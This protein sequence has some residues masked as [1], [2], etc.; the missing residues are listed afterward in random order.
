MSKPNSLKPARQSHLHW[1][2]ADDL[3]VNPVAQRE[4]NLGWANHI[5][6]NF[7]L[8]KMQVPHVNKR[9]DGSLYIMEGQHTVWAYRQW[10]GAGQ[11][12]QVWLYD[13]LSEREEAEFFLSLNDKKGIDSL[14][15]FR[16][17]VTAG[18]EAECDIDRIVR[19]NGAVVGSGKK[20]GNHISA[21]G[22][23]L[24]I[25]GQHGAAVLGRTIRTIDLAFSEGGYE[26][27]VLLGI[28]AVYG[29]YGGDVDEEMLILK[30]G[31]LRNGWKTLVQRAQLLRD[32][33]GVTQSV[34]AAAAVVEVYNA[35]RGG[36]KLMT[37]WSAAEVVETAKANA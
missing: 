21:V 15:K 12:I 36:V 7:D 22:T 6:Q 33:H 31:K 20:N 4:F 11:Q 19:A 32:S 27:P 28:A 8:D 25:Y 10:L 30:L 5:L 29:R 9:T 24:T 26:R 1:V 37:W 18:R 3:V 13:G 23:L 2:K 16:A 17:A 34:A 14:P 35:G